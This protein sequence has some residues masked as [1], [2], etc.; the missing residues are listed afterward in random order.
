MYTLKSITIF[1][2]LGLILVAATST[3]LGACAVED[4]NYPEC[5]NEGTP[6]WVCSR[7]VCPATT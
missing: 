2:S 3:N 6:Y 5:P 1:L 7:Y 4:M